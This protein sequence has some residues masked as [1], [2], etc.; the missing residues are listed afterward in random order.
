MWNHGTTDRGLVDAV[1]F[2]QL[3]RPF[4][5][6]ELVAG[7]ERAPLLHKSIKIRNQALAA[8]RLF[9]SESLVTST[10]EKNRAAI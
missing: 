6:S 2:Q 8:R 7:P 10:G 5:K 3:W 4:V 1:G 9:L